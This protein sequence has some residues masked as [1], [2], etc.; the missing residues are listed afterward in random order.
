MIS[1]NCLPEV[2]Q[3]A[4]AEPSSLQI[5]SF[6]KQYVHAISWVGHAS[7]QNALVGMVLTSIRHCR[8]VPY[9]VTL[10][11]LLDQLM[12]WFPWMLPYIQPFIVE[13][14]SEVFSNAYAA[15]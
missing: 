4:L 12:V 10:V 3:R 13:V 5:N 1:F 14:Y 8:S 7:L 6:C 11:R 2:L 15:G 9:K